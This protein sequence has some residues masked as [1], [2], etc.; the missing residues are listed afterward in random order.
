MRMVTLL[1]FCLYLATPGFAQN[2]VLMNGSVIDGTGKPRILA[3][4][5]IREG[6]I[7]DIGPLKPLA[8]EM[9]FDVKG[10]VVAPGFID[11]QTLSP[12]TIQKDPAATAVVSQ[13]VTTAVL[14]SDGTGPYSVEEFMLPF[15]EKPPAVNIAMVVGHATVRRQIMGPDFRRP[16]TPDEIQRMSELVSDAMKQ[17]AFGVGSDLQ[18][19]P[20][21]FSTPEEVMALAKVITRFG[22]TFLLKLR[23]EDDK[24][25]D[26]V[27]EAVA[28]ARDAKIPVQVLTTNK[29]AIAE[30]DKA[31]ATRVDIGA[32]SYSFAQ[33]AAE[34]GVML[35]R[36]VQR[37]SGAPATRMGLRERGILKKGAP[38]DLAIFNPQTISAGI[39]HVFVNGTMIVK[40]GQLTDARPGQALR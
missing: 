9:T 31:R 14:G 3:N 36:A 2:L 4:V 28:L 23:N 16:A 1:S 38:A 6:K 20:A 29:T 21:S 39:K 5:R 8:G 25:S 12:S 40:D 7:A 33:L 18:Q 22:G 19:E 27:K 13:G 24:L 10:M 11:L 26:A 32:D 17:G 34:K 37:M 30:F 35:E 15:D